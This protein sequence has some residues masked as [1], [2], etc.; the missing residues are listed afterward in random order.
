MD[1]SRNHLSGPIPDS[2]SNLKSLNLLDLSHNSLS[3][4]IPNALRGITSL[5]ALILTGNAMH[6]T[7]VPNNA[8]KGLK[9]ITTL[10]LSDMGLEGPIPESLGEMPR[11]RVLHLD[12]N[13][14][15]GSIPQ[16][17]RRLEKLSELRVDGNRLTGPI[18]FSKEVVWRMGEK[19]RVYNNSGLCFDASSGRYEGIASMSGIGY[20]NGGM[21]SEVGGGGVSSR[22]TK[23]L[24]WS[25][26]HDP[27]FKSNSSGFAHR[28]CSLR[29]LV[30][31][32]GLLLSCLL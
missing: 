30:L 26:G 25:S 2:I 29:L 9:E 3:G 14:F 12:G 27:E 5:R 23:H 32:T 28:C 21:E 13:K 22:S 19:L 24:S 16:S 11:L 1:L 6:S 18:P 10:V 20:C 15:N 4:P 17:F 31:I 7:I 8:F